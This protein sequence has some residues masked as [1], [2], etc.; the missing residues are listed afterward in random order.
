MQGNGLIVLRTRIARQ[1]TLIKR[2]YRMAVMVQII[3]NG[4]GIPAE[5]QDKIFYPLVSVVLMDMS[6]VDPGSG[7]SSASTT[8][9][10]SSTANPG[11]PASPCCFPSPNAW[12]KNRGHE[13]RLDN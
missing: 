3:D 4:P 11:V 13:T 12:N 7:F 10:S 1:V 8:A 9:L 6:G 2:R 5:L